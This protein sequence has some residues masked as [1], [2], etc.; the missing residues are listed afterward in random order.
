MRHSGIVQSLR[1]HIPS[2]ERSKRNTGHWRDAGG[3]SDNGVIWLSL[4]KFLAGK[5]QKTSDWRGNLM[6]MANAREPHRDIFDYFARW[7][8]DIRF[9]VGGVCK[10]GLFGL[11]AVGRHSQRTLTVGVG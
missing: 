6:S 11:F 3:W 5:P 8:V 9:T 4:A 2:C 7:V 1:G 10:V